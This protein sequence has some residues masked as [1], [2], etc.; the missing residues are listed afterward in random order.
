MKLKAGFS[1]FLI[2]LSACSALWPACGETVLA[3]EASTIGG[4]RALPLSVL[5]EESSRLGDLLKADPSRELAGVELF[6]L[7]T[8]ARSYLA[9]GLY[10][11]AEGWF[12]QLSA[13]DR[14]GL[15]EEPIFNGLLLSAIGQG[16]WPRAEEL[17]SMEGRPS[18]EIDNA[19]FMRLLRHMADQ[20]QQLAALELIDGLSMRDESRLTLSVLAYKGFLLREMGLLS[21]ASDFYESMLERLSEPDALHPS[22]AAGEDLF[23]LGAADTA[24]LMNERIR[25][26]LRYGELFWSE[27]VENRNWARFQ[28]A[29]L[30]MLDNGYEA[31]EAAF[32]RIG[33]DS[34]WDPASSW[35]VFLREHTSAMK[36]YSEV[37]RDNRP[38][39]GEMVP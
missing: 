5:E 7:L 39:L 33:P 6:K 13:A 17:I 20:G 37:L 25:A 34:L 23:L 38:P 35:A 18:M 29:Q 36:T 9:Y 19:A 12:I 14:E 1:Q 3:S 22:V 15:Y 2:V 24:F 30:D 31:A 10:K 8:L 28:L 21:E 16:D 4:Y 32:A 27:D 26:R 11:E